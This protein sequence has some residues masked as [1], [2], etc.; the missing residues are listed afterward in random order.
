MQQINKINRL[1]EQNYLNLNKEQ[2]KE[3]KK[4]NEEEEMDKRDQR[5]KEKQI[6]DEKYEYIKR[7]MIN[8]KRFNTDIKQLKYGYKIQNDS[9]DD[10]FKINF[11]KFTV[12]NK[13]NHSYNFYI[14]SIFKNAKY[15]E[16]E[17]YYNNMIEN[18]VE[19]KKLLNQ[20][21]KNDYNK[22]IESYEIGEHRI[23]QYFGE[24]TE[25]NYFILF[26]FNSNFYW[27]DV[28]DSF[29]KIIESKKYKTIN[30]LFKGN[31]FHEVP[32]NMNP[33]KY[34]LD[35]DFDQSYQEGDILYF[36]DEYFNT[37]NEYKDD[38]F[39]GKIP[40]EAYSVDDY[41]VILT[42]NN[43]DFGKKTC[44]VIIPNIL[45]L[46]RE[47]IKIIHIY[48]INKLKEKEDDLINKIIN[49]NIIDIKVY[50]ENHPMRAIGAYK[51]Q[52]DGKQKQKIY[53]DKNI[54]ESYKALLNDDR[55]ILPEDIYYE[56]DYELTN[57]NKK[58][59]ANIKFNE[60]KIM[61]LIPYYKQNY[62]IESITKNIINITK[63]TPYEE[64][65]IICD[66]IHENQKGLFLIIY[67]NCI[68][69]GCFKDEKEPKKYL[70]IY[71]GN[72]EI[73]A[74]KQND[75][76]EEDEEEQEQEIKRKKDLGEYVENQLKFIRE[77]EYMSVENNLKKIYANY[78]KHVYNNKS[79]QPI[80]MEDF[81]T[82]NTIHIHSP[83]GSGKTQMLK[84]LFKQYLNINPEK[85]ILFM[86]SDIIF[87][88]ELTAVLKELNFIN[89]SDVEGKVDEYDRMI[90][91]M[92]SLHRIKTIN[93]DFVVIDEVEKFMDSLLNIGKLGKASTRKLNLDNLL[94]IFRNQ[95]IKLI[96]MDA[97]ASQRTYNIWADMK[98]KIKV[99]IN[100]YNPHEENKYDLL[101]DIEKQTDDMR[102]DIFNGK[103]IIFSS[104]TKSA[105]TKIVNIVIHKLKKL[106]YTLDQSRYK[107]YT[108]DTPEEVT[109]K[110]FENVNE[111]WKQY[112]GVFYSPKILAGIS[113]T[114]VHFYK[115]YS[116]Q[117]GHLGA[118]STLQQIY[119]ARDIETKTYQILLNTRPTSE[120]T[121]EDILNTYNAARY[122]KTNK[123]EL[124]D[125]LKELLA[126]N[127]RFD[128]DD[129][130]MRYLNDSLE[131]KILIE[132]ILHTNQ[133]KCNYIK[134]ILI[135]FNSISKNVNVI[136]NDNT[137][138]T[139]KTNDKYLTYV[140]QYYID[141]KYIHQI[142][143]EDLIIGKGQIKIN[144]DEGH[145]KTKQEEFLYSYRQMCKYLPVIRK[146]IENQTTFEAKKYFMEQAFKNNKIN[147]TLNEFI[148]IKKIQEISP[149]IDNIC[150]YK[151][152]NLEQTYESVLI[153]KTSLATRFVK[154]LLTIQKN[155]E[156]A[157]KYNYNKYSPKQDDNIHPLIYNHIVKSNQP[158]NGRKN[159]KSEELLT[160]DTNTIKESLLEMIQIY[161]DDKIFK[162][163]LYYIKN[164]YYS[165]K[166]KF[167]FNIEKG[168][169]FL[170]DDV[171]NVKLI[172]L[173]NKILEPVFMSHLKTCDRKDKRGLYTLKPITVYGEPIII[174]NKIV[175]K[176]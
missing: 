167:P 41:N 135:E 150:D 94:S 59:I 172:N 95:N 155:K 14:N 18:L 175:W 157:D 102:N 61:N 156:P 88:K 165:D 129:N 26:E 8:K 68:Q 79:A 146:N 60:T 92:N 63:N 100:K 139:N 81:K 44:H 93:Y 87:G 12:V 17:T 56:L 159:M 58:S 2:Q 7:K 62:Y 48:I 52:K 152:A 40:D 38:I 10:E 85:R 140:Q 64:K 75:K 73:E 45:F 50:N 39:Y 122:I 148:Q 13:D 99:Y 110:D 118:L 166:N 33:I 21:E 25:I 103:N 147:K 11:N 83:C 84:D 154:T 163:I 80:N 89:Y 125:Q 78:E 49:S 29:I 117:T 15:N 6:N 5:I 70:K 53:K 96:T 67:E 126:H 65:C 151:Y 123:I 174:D 169:L 108:V 158:T 137:K 9:S 104:D 133:K 149:D 51:I 24:I 91:C 134:D 109:K 86:T 130:G 162:N 106:G 121:K 69:L 127:A 19:Q 30:N 1:F 31:Y 72:T 173:A 34:F 132:N 120:I 97:Y 23:I 145:K 136:K 115:H 98:R 141:N 90:I 28:Y 36:I 77:H 16:I 112:L 22:I 111:T 116:Y 160:F 47:L 43:P 42:E 119:R 138:D 71:Q 27:S 128:W 168:K 171:S 4:L 37:F 82:H 124:E 3:F 20:K 101:F 54:Q 74:D 46:N 164:N 143:P 55:N 32:D 57:K 170:E 153:K 66:R 131:N 105:I 161:D 114:S 144:K 107:I 113:F 35:L 76:D 142:T 176:S